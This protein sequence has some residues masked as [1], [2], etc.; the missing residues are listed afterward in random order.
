MFSIFRIGEVV[1]IN[2]LCRSGVFISVYSVVYLLYWLFDFNMFIEIFLWMII[3]LIVSLVGG[4][5]KSRKRQIIIFLMHYI[6]MS[7]LTDGVLSE[8]VSIQFIAG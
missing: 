5:G 8:I 4:A 1:N 7:F 3:F 6:L 2:K